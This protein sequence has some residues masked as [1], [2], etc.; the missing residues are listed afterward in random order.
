[1]LSRNFSDAQGRWKIVSSWAPN[2]TRLRLLE[3]ATDDE[4]K[5]ESDGYFLAGRRGLDGV[6]SRGLIYKNTFKL[7]QNGNGH[8]YDLRIN[9]S[10]GRFLTIVSKKYGET[11]VAKRISK[12]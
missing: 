3:L 1:M 10:N 8:G 5:I 6:L 9:E 12:K 11:I 4:I 7:F 2:P